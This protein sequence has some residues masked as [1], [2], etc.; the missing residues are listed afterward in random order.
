MATSKSGSKASSAKSSAKKP[1]NSTS[2]KNVKTE[3]VVAKRPKFVLKRPVFKKVDGTPNYPAIILSE[4]VGTFVLTLV[5]LLSLQDVAA[6][7]VG[8]TVAVLVLSVGAVS[9]AHL[10]PAVS[11]GLWS[12]RKLRGLLL[13]VYWLA[14]FAGAAVAILVLGLFNGG[15]YHLDFSHF[16]NVHWGI[17]GAE[18]LGTAVFL[19]GLIAVVSNDKLSQVGKAF[20][21]GLSLT[22]GILVSGA[23]FTALQTSVYN[24]YSQKQQAETQSTAEQKLPAE[25]YIKGATLNPA[26][27]LASTEYTENQLNR[28]SAGADEAQYSRLSLEVILGTLV[29]AAL[30]A[31]LYLLV[32]YAN[33]RQ[34]A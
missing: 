24:E 22:I 11:F 33:R 34:N 10:N 6:L 25:L 9:G 13:P 27:A 30:G 3:A 7:Y 17:L 4:L 12:A 20:G 29:G 19:F 1:T 18:L 8:L 31:N 21:V 28:L 16:S 26:V 23:G 5:A 15:S 14:Q 32:A 2:T